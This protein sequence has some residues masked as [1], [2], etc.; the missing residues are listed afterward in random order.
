VKKSHFALLFILLPL[1]E[2]EVGAIAFS[3]FL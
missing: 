2:L 3:P 1:Y